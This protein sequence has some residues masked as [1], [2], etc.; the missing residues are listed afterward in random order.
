MHVTSSANPF[1]RAAR[2]REL[3][4]ASASLLSYLARWVEK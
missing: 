2:Y 1:T 3:R 4:E